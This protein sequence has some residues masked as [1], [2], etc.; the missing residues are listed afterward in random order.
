MARPKQRLDP[1]VIGAVRACVA[2]EF[3]LLCLGT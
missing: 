3:R 2:A 1:A